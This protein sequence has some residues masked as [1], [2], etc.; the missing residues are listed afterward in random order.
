MDVYESPGLSVAI[1]SR[2]EPVYV[3]AFGFADKESEETLTTQH[4]FRIASVTKPI[5]SAGVLL[6][7]EGGK[8]RLGDHIFGANSILGEEYRTPPGREDI[9]AITVDH[10]LTH[11]AGGWGN[12]HDD[13]MFMNKRMDHRELI[14]WT[15][16]NIA[17]TSEPGKNYSY[18]N[19]GYCLLGRVIERVSEKKYD[20]YTM[21]AVLARCGISDM[22]IGGNTLVERATKEVRYYSQERGMDPYDLNVARMDSHGGWIATP[23]DLLRFFVKIDGFSNA[24]LLSRDTLKISNCSPPS[25]GWG[26]GEDVLDG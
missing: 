14:N 9:E 26:C 13:P 23:T 12:T 25:W 20:Q 19:F 18:S 4:R 15:L 7:M 8:L 6:L 22:Q 1:G 21:D 3:E 2:G 24:Q 17:L 16:N 10:L 11:T 5:T